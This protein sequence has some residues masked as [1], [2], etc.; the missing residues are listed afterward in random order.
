MEPASI[1]F[2][3]WSINGSQSLIIII[4]FFSGFLT[5]VLLLAN[6]VYAKNREVKKMR[7]DFLATGKIEK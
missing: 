5:G 3:V 7:K 1:K 2:L 4:T 6:Q